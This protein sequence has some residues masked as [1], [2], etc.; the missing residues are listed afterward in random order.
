MAFNWGVLW[1][2]GGSG[3]SYSQILVAEFNLRS[4]SAY[5]DSLQTS[6]HQLVAALTYF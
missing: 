1:F 6:E 2:S 4:T 5:F 3:C